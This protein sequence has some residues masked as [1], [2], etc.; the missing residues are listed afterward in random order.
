ETTIGM[1]QKA[2]DYVTW[3]EVDADTLTE[4]I[5]TRGRL[6][7]DK[8]IT[9][10]HVKAN[11]DFSSIADMAAAIVEGKFQ[12]KDLAEVK[13]LLRLHPARKGLEGIKRSV[14]AGGALGYRGEKINDL[15]R[16]MM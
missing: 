12:Y 15:M 2:K 5:S 1:L 9:D 16:R 10:D 7:G 14:Q 3:G 13:P 4:A 6:I 8:P 11:T